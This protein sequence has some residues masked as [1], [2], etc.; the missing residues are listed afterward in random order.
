[1]TPPTDL[2]AR[3]GGRP[4][5]TSWKNWARGVSG[6]VGA[7]IASTPPIQITAYD[8]AS[9]ELGLAAGARFASRGQ[10][11]IR[12][13]TGGIRGSFLPA[14]YCPDLDL[15]HPAQPCRRRG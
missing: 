10:T 6:W 5:G 12:N 15:R 7:C 8:M 9:A 1:M 4:S 11:T 13:V 2:S 3:R 14:G